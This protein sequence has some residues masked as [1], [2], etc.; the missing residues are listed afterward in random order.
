M[1]TLRHMSMSHNNR[2][3]PFS[4]KY[5]DYGE[6]SSSTPVFDPYDPNADIKKTWGAYV[7]LPRETIR[8]RPEDSFDIDHERL[9]DAYKGYS[10]TL[11]TDRLIRRISMEE[12]FGTTLMFPLQ[13]H[14]KSMQ[15][16]W[17]T[18]RFNDT[19]L[20]KVA[21][22]GIPR[23]LSY[24]KSSQSASIHR[25]AKAFEMEHGF[26]RTDIGKAT[27][28]SH[29]EQMANAVIETAEYGA[30]L[31]ALFHPLYR[32]PYESQRV[33]G[34]RD[35]EALYQSFSDE[36]RNW[37]M[38]QKSSTGF[39][40]MIENGR[41]ALNKRNQKAGDLWILPQ[42]IRKYVDDQTMLKAFFIS[43]RKTGE[44]YSESLRALGGTRYV[45][46]R[47]YITGDGEGSHDTMDR[48]Q[49]IGNFF[50]IDNSSLENVPASEYRTNM[51]DVRVYNES[52][53]QFQPV[54]LKRSWEYLGLFD[55]TEGRDYAQLSNI[56]N[57]FFAP[58]YSWG[59]FLTENG[60]MDMFAGTLLSK[61]SETI[62]HFVDHVVNGS[63]RA[64]NRPQNASS[65]SSSSSSLAHSMNM[66]HVGGREQGSTGARFSRNEAKVTPAE[67]ER[68]FTGQDESSRKKEAAFVV[69]RLNELDT[70]FKTH[71]M[72]TYWRSLN[73]RNVDDIDKTVLGD[74]WSSFAPTSLEAETEAAA[75]DVLAKKSIFKGA[76]TDVESHRR[77]THGSRESV[78]HASHEHDQQT[79]RW[80]SVGEN[81]PEINPY[82]VFVT[83]S[84]ARASAATLP[85]A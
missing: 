48:N 30:I 54:S 17:D 84:Y 24:S 57:A 23:M 62:Q 28:W 53:D 3:Q 14:D 20:D 34:E 70:Q 65:S 4:T 58:Y 83:P 1:S 55:T 59:H 32:D 38:I 43:G 36:I 51:M 85:F 11:M 49:T 2:Y 63:R 82:K 60:A 19:M 81:T 15:I 8:P 41:M 13:R 67:I 79:P 12:R 22:E 5:T 10:S 40:T 33:V 27:Y 31:T 64:S 44:S 80:K 42:G 69:K 6:P 21:E 47:D 35:L 18:I 78:Q 26:M 50:R 29:L 16:A 71:L 46:S 73:E 72:A 52:A 77:A 68:R 37:A 66:M 61:T 25:M 39:Q 9:P 56:G 75:K 74:F 45:E 76:L 7:G